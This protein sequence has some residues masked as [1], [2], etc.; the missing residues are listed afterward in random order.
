MKKVYYPDSKKRKLVIGQGLSSLREARDN[1]DPDLMARLQDMVAR[2]GG[3]SIDLAS[4]GLESLAPGTMVPVDRKKVLTIVKKFIEI[5][6]GK[7]SLLARLK[8]I[9]TESLH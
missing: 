9:M 5:Q 4:P 8:T 7:T 6:A 2:K 3:K 1:I